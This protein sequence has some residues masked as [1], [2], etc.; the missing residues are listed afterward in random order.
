MSGIG[1]PVPAI[2]PEM[3][4]FYD[5]TA[6]HELWL[7]RCSACGAFRFPAREVCSECLSADS[8]WERASGRGEIWSFTILHQVY[9]PAFAAEAPYAVVIVKLDEGPKLTSN[10]RGTAARDVRIGTRVEVGFEEFGG[11]TLPVFMKAGTAAE[12]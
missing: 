6:R 10:L 1:K 9:H 11:V 4:P 7:Q 5:G 8:T 12:F 2:T 3:Q